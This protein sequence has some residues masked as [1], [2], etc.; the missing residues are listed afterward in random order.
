MHVPYYVLLRAENN[1]GGITE[2]LSSPVLL[3]INDARP[4]DVMDG[5]DFT[6]DDSNHG[7]Q[8]MIQGRTRNYVW[9][10]I[11]DVFLVL[12]EMEISN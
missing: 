12:I 2:T 10:P 3:D 5:D 4:G 11:P 1:A 6:E 7:D 8:T 9:I